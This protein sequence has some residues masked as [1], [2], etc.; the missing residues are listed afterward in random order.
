MFSTDLAGHNCKTIS[1]STIS[2]FHIGLCCLIN[3][4]GIFKPGPVEWQSTDDMRNVMK[5][6]LWGTIDMTKKM[7][8]LL[9]RRK[10]RVINITSVAGKKD[11]FNCVFDV[12]IFILQKRFSHCNNFS[13]Y[14]FQKEF[15]F[16]SINIS[17]GKCP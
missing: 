10:G 2:L 11:F 5:V 17:K 9:K 8:P 16:K 14:C 4:A 15:Q 3:N 7:L 13:I 6:N 12:D 1:T